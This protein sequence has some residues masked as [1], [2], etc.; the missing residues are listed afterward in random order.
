MIEK[1]LSYQGLFFFLK[2]A[3]FHFFTFIKDVTALILP[4]S[5]ESR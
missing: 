1:S 4:I 3:I 5:N 2:E